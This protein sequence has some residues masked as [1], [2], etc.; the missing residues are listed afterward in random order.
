MLKRKGVKIELIQ[1]LMQL[2]FV[3]RAKRGGLCSVL[4]PRLSFSR[5]GAEF[6]KKTLREELVK[7]C[8]RSTVK[9]LCK[10]VDKS[11][12]EDLPDP[13]DDF[14]ILYLDANVSSPSSYQLIL[15]TSLVEPLWPCPNSPSPS[16]RISLCQRG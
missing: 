12:L 4:G 3:N 7:I 9:E 5:K 11:L 10:A 2:K 8:P 16:W 1:D 14:E 13:D 15:I 6:I